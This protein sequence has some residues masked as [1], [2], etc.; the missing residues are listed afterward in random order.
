MAN[1]PLAFAE[2]LVGAIIADAAI[3]GDTIANVVKGQAT[4]HPLSGSSSST[5]G[6]SSSSTSGGSGGSPPKAQITGSTYVNPF[7]GAN[8][9]R[10]DQGVD[11]TITKPVVAPGDFLVKHISNIPGFGTYIA[12]VLLDG[13]LGGRGVYFAEG[14]T[15]ASGVT[16]GEVVKQGQPIANPAKGPYGTGVIE[17]GWAD[18]TS[19]WFAPLAQGTGGYTEGDS[20]AAGASFNRFIHALGGPLGTLHTLIGGVSGMGLP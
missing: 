6:S 5:T 16:V 17:S 19:N 13:V 18:I 3:K 7:P 8:A 20:T 14:L 4:T 1:L 15:P 2:L 9:S 10:V 12:G 11:Y